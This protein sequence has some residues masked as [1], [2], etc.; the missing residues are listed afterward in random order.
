MKTD[1][2]SAKS[3]PS[4]VPGPGTPPQPALAAVKPKKKVTLQTIKSNVNVLDDMLPVDDSVGVTFESRL[5][6]LYVILISL[7][8]L[9]RGQALELGK[10]SDTGG[11]VRRC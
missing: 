9:V 8:G 4:S 11:Q 3:P 1:S 7:H 10:D 6:G 5:D 2:E